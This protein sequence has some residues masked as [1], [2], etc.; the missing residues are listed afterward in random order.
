M[1]QL[2]DEKGC[3]VPQ[4]ALAWVLRQPGLDVYALVGARTGAE[5]QANAEV[6]D[7]PLTAAEM[8]WLDLRRQER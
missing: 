2:A 1:R 4:V 5:C 3:T 7:L 8:E 6:F